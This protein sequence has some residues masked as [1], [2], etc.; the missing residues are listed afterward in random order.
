MDLDDEYQQVRSSL[1]NFWV[2]V[3][4]FTEDDPRLNVEEATKGEDVNVHGA[5]L[6]PAETRLAGS[7]LPRRRLR[8]SSNIANPPPCTLALSWD[9][10]TGWIL[11]KPFIV[12]TIL[13][14]AR[15]PKTA[16]AVLEPRPRPDSWESR[17]LPKT[18]LKKKYATSTSSTSNIK[19]LQP[20]PT[21]HVQLVHQVNLQL[22]RGFVHFHPRNQTLE[23]L[24]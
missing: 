7:T 6:S 10:C 19:S 21:S 14:K 24:T 5:C 8:A 9:L 23:K 12:T 15:K 13:P 22:Q 3:F 20:L 18:T 17:N 4:R 16:K 11:R 1:W 2:S